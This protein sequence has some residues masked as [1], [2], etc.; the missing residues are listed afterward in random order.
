MKQNL[1]ADVSTLTTLGMPIINKIANAEQC[2]ICDYVQEVIME[3]E[4]LLEIDLGYGILSILVLDNEIK[5]SFKPSA[6]LEKSLVDIM[7][8][9]E[10]PVFTQ[11]STK[12]LKRL[13]TAYKDIF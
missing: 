8:G 7:N 9:G 11:L 5:Y 10:S 1:L 13:E 2:C 6:K 12:L 4:D 3:D